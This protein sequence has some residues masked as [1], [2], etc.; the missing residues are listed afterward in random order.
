MRRFAM[1]LM[2]N[3]PL[4]FLAPYIMKFAVGAKRM[5]RIR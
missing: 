2:F 4:G 5:R 1:W 3:V